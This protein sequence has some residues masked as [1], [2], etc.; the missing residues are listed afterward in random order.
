MAADDK[1]GR[2]APDVSDAGSADAG[3]PHPGTED[4]PAAPSGPPAAA[5]VVRTV[6]VTV[7][8]VAVLALSVLLFLQH[9]SLRS[10]RAADADRARAE[11]IAADYA[12]KAA[13]MDYRDLTPWLNAM[14]TGVTPELGKKFDAIADTMREVLPPLRMTTTG[15]AL[16]GKVT[17]E[18]NGIYTVKVAVDVS[19]QNVQAPQGTVS[20]TAYGVTL[21]RG[22]DWIITEVG[23]SAN[24]NAVLGG[25]GGAPAPPS[26]SPA[27]GAVVPPTVPELP[28]PPALPN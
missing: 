1:H 18:V 2:T 14:K 25:L 7:L 8:V 28:P 4:R 19:S 24:P 20:T 26:S 15:K 9:R 16:F 23:D 11:Q 27:P 21:D 12:V 13:T 22:R 17:S 3:T 5:H 6:L 10:E